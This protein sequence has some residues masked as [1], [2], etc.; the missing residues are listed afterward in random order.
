MADT[1]STGAAS[2]EPGATTEGVDNTPASGTTPEGQ[3]PAGTPAE[4]STEGEGSKTTEEVSYEFK[5]PEGFQLDQARTD[6]FTAIAKDLKLPADKAQALVDLAVKAEQQRIEQHQT[7]IADWTK[8]SQEHKTLGGDKLLENLAVAKKTYD[9]LPAERATE[10]KGILN[11]TGL[12]AH[13]VMFELFHAIGSAL[14]EASF[15]KGAAPAP[16]A[17]SLA[18]RMYPKMNP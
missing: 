3:T 13:P 9:L 4:G 7:L 15:V 8:Q 2:T 14:S 16:G 18:Q 12:E 17:E 6:E 10:L 5:V 11:A 1:T